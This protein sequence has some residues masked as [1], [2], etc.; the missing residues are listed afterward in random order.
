MKNDNKRNEQFLMRLHIF[1][2]GV[3]N[4]NYRRFRGHSIFGT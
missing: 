2:K 3:I 4:N 1:A